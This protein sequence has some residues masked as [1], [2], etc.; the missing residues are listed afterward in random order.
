[1]PR[2]DVVRVSTAPGTDTFRVTVDDLGSSTRHSVAIDAPP[3][4]VATGYPTLEAFVAASFRF[5]LERE[6]KESILDSFEIREIGR[7]F[8]DWERALGG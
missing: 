6:P 2:I 3:P 1:M 8:P 7:Y 5:L 4:D